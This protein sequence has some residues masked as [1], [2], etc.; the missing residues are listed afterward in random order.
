[1]E[2]IEHFKP[3]VQFPH[4]AFS[5]SNLYYTCEHCQNA[6]GS[7]WSPDIL[8]PDADSYLFIT[9]FEFDYITGELRP[10][11]SADAAAQSCARATI[12]AYDLDSHY[13]RE[14]RKRRLRSWQRSHDCHIDDESD[15]DFLET[16]S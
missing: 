6:K 13:R 7:Y 10:N 12:D 5:W 3:K 4:E 2:P 15:R 14:R 8:R 9:Y 11:Q 16:A 1:M